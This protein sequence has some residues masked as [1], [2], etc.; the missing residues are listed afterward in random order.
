MHDPVPPG[1][2]K[3]VAAVAISIAVHALIGLAWWATADHP[4]IA[5]MSLGTAVDGPD[6]GEAIF[7][8]RE[9]PSE[10]QRPAPPPQPKVGATSPPAPLPTAITSAGPGPANPGAVTQSG[11]SP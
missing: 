7:V 11:I 3:V 2:G 6:D 1:R 4:A 8:L 5:A 10:P 9:P